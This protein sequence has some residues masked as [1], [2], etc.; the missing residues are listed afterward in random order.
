MA[1]TT[2][3]RAQRYG[4]YVT[5]SGTEI[6]AHFDVAEDETEG[7]F[8]WFVRALEDAYAFKRHDTVGD[9]LD[10]IMED[11]FERRYGRKQTPRDDVGFA[12]VGVVFMSLMA[13]IDDPYETKSGQET[14]AGRTKDF[15]EELSGYAED[16]LGMPRGS[17]K[18]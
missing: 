10:R 16:M 14:L 17:L 9:R 5:R 11:I 7:R 6:T 18:K 15:I 3:T 8:A 2:K 12:L 4:G 1:K 13:G